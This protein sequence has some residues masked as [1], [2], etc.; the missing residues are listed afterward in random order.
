MILVAY[1]CILDPRLPHT[2]T[3]TRTNNRPIQLRPDDDEELE[4][5]VSGDEIKRRS[6]SGS[7]DT[8]RSDAGSNSDAEVL[9]HF[10]PYQRLLTI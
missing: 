6:D 4:A 2:M 5:S 8:G 9:A 7:E 3:S 1:P 10:I